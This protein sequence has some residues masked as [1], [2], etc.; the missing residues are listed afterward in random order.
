MSHTLLQSDPY[1][2]YEIDL[3]L[4]PEPVT[5]SH[6]M[7][8]LDIVNYVYT[9]EYQ[10]EVIKHG[11]SVDK[12]S[13]PG[14]RV[15]RQ[16]GHLL[17]WSKQLAAGSAG[18]DMREIDSRY[19]CKSGKNLNRIGMKITIRD[20][21]NVES[22]SRA[23]KHLHVKQLERKMIKEYKEK[24]GELPIGNIKDESYIDNKTCVTKSTWDR[25]FYFD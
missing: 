1:P 12:K 19:C 16:A 13:I 2:V 24:H 21:T 3:A 4:I 18:D 20:L 11:I 25:L 22:P 23:D 10:G 15:Y 17:G 9:F 6:I 7:K 8:S 5:I 14:E